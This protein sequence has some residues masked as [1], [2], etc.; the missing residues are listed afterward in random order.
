[1]KPQPQNENKHFK[2][3]FWILA[4]VNYRNW[5]GSSLP[6]TSSCVQDCIGQIKRNLITHLNEH[7]TCEES[8]V[9][10][11]LLNNP[12]V[13]TKIIL[14]RVVNYVIHS[15]DAALSKLCNSFY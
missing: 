12:T 13:T 14:I 7:R 4:I 8:E 2:N 9:C 11:H 15:T 3:Y 10:E 6:L 5:L 1:M